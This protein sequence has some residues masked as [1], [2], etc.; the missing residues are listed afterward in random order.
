MRH[1]I[2]HCR[3]H[4]LPSWSIQPVSELM[5]YYP[6]TIPCQCPPA[7]FEV[8]HLAGFEAV[9]Y[10]SPFRSRPA[11][12]ETG[13]V[14]NRAFTHTYVHTVIQEIFVVKNFCCRRRLG[15]L[16]TRNIFDTHST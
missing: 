15:K 2:L 5:N 4:V 8:V 7:S 10:A 11:G 9:H 16:N 6:V 13:W 12:F 3:L 14:A 1:E